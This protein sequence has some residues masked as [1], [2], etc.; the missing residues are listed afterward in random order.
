MWASSVTS[1]GRVSDWNDDDAAMEMVTAT[2]MAV[3]AAIVILLLTMPPPRMPRVASCL[4][5]CPFGCKFYPA[6]IYCLLSS[7]WL[8]ERYL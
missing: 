2:S 5:L 7:L 3:D 8:I 6:P 1:A 4:W